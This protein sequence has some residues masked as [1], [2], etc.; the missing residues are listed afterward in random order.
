MLAPT[1]RLLLS[2][3]DT[4]ECAYFLTPDGV[5]L[6]GYGWLAAEKEALSRSKSRKPNH[7]KLGTEEFMLAGH[8]TKSGYPFLIENDAFSIQFGE[9]NNHSLAFRGAGVA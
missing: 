8:G 1:P 2:G 6:L 3:H 5:C 9:F 7:I 4:I